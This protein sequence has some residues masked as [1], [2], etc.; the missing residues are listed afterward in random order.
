LLTAT[1]APSLTYSVI[2]P[3]GR[4]Q[5][6]TAT[7]DF[8]TVAIGSSGVLHFTAANQTQ[9]PLLVP[10]IAVEGRYFALSGPSPSGQV[11]QSQQQAAFDVQFTPLS[12]GNFTADLTIA[13]RTYSLAAT[14]PPLPLPV[15][16]LSVNLPQAQSAQQGSV[17]V[18]FDAPAAGDGSGSLTLDFQPSTFAGKDLAVAFAAG[19]RTLAFTFSAGDTE[20]RFGTQTAALFQTG[21]TAGTISFAAAIGSTSAGQSVTISPAEVSISTVQADRALTGLSLAIT[22]YDNTQSVSVLTFTFFDAAGN[23][24]TP[25]AVMTDVRT[26][27]QTYYSASDLGGIFR[28]NSQ[29]PVTGDTSLIRSVEV[30][31]TNSAG[32]LKSNRISF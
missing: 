18:T 20:A 32:T 7:I 15:P 1:V 17:A 19:G 8:G 6:G 25:G 23:V 10:A 9:S 5:L 30:Q 4:R 13:D 22:G 24:I 29:F 26:D 16:Q 2:L 31:L 21:T 27:F 14:A 3:S 12:S 28:L 11:L